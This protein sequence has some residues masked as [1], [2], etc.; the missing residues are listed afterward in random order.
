MPEKTVRKEGLT[1]A[2]ILSRYKFAIGGTLALLALENLIQV[3][4][5]L[6]L[7]RAIDGLIAG[8]VTAFFIFI[9]L[10]MSGLAVGIVRRV[11][12]TRVYQRIYR[13]AACE[14]VE[15]ENARDASVTQ[16]TARANFVSEFVEFFEYFLPM[17][18]A[19]MATLVGAIVMLAVISP[20]LAGAAMLI[21]VAVAGVFAIASPHLQKLNAALNDEMERQVEILEKRQQQGVRAHFSALAH[22]RIRLSDYEAQNF[23]LTFFL[24]IVLTSAA[25]WLLVVVDQKSV[26]QVFAAL[27]Y[28]LQFTESVVVLPY[29]YQQ[30]IRTREISDRLAA[31]PEADAHDA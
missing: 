7:G 22:W 16:V 15:K 24:T 5:P 25:V 4:E 27:T 30:F 23:G 9:G 13:E 28:I 19:S 11:Y 18:L 12:D 26:G 29:T 6:F 21:G 2:A 20:P 17:A 10:A 14:T 8:E 1:H 31:G 3:I